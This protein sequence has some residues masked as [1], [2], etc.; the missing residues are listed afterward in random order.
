MI[1]LSLLHDYFADY[2]LWDWLAF[3][4]QPIMAAPFIIYAVIW[5]YRRMGW[6][7]NGKRSN[8]QRINNTNLECK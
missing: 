5:L 8:D 3:I 2:T 6:N 7:I 4:L 1:L